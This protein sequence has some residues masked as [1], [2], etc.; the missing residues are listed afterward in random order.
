M[1][2]RSSG[3][4]IASAFSWQQGYNRSCLV[5]DPVDVNHA[6]SIRKFSR[7]PTKVHFCDQ[8]EKKY[9]SVSYRPVRYHMSKAAAGSGAKAKQPKPKPPQPAVGLFDML[10]QALSD[11]VHTEHIHPPS[12]VDLVDQA[13]AN[14]KANPSAI[15]PLVF[16]FSTVASPPEGVF[17][18]FADLLRTRYLRHIAQVLCARTSDFWRFHKFMSKQAM[19]SPELFDFLGSLA[20]TASETDPQSLASLF[21]K[22]VF[23][24]YSDYLTNRT[25]LPHIV[26]LIF[27]HTESDES[28]RDSRVPQIL[29]RCTNDETQY[30]ILSHTVMHERI[31]SSK[32]CELYAQK[33]TEGL[34]TVDYQPYAVHILRYLAPIN[35]DLLQKNLD[36]I[37]SLVEDSRPTLQTALV[38]LLVDS[39]QEQLL[40]TLIDNTDRLDVLSLS[41]HLVSELGTI[42][43]QLLLALFKKIGSANIE[44]VCTERCT[45]DS[46]VGPLQ[47]GRLTNTWNSAAV[48]STVI[49]HIQNLPLPQWNVEFALCKLLLKQPMDSSSAQIWQQLFN[50]LSVQIGEMMRDEEMTE[51]IF[52]IVGFY[53]SATT[54]IALLEKLQPA[55]EPVVSVAK[56]KCK[57]ACTKFLAIVADLGPKFKHVVNT[58]ILVQ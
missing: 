57:V 32:L 30:V 34:E 41:L 26:S 54:D 53:L 23:P 38:Q 9:V 44:P 36:K 35:A 20:Q 12:F 3:D 48:N 47:L 55:L 11:F 14:K 52:D 49:N 6:A 37:G 2:F 51:L 10:N 33:V 58:L 40:S 8:F 28:A 50:Q 56:E 21:T 46:P 1:P 31:F 13:V 4:I 15:D 5:V 22:N 7:D 17:R 16:S 42:S 25:L 45:V 39:N 43:P 27:A 18:K 19:D 24:M 29:E